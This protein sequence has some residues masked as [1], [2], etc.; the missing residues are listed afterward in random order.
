[1][2][3]WSWANAASCALGGEPRRLQ[4]V[5]LGFG[6]IVASE[7]EHRTCSCLW[8]EVGERQYKAT[9]RLSP[10][11]AAGVRRER[12]DPALALGLRCPRPGQQ[13]SQ[14]TARTGCAALKLH[15]P[16]S[17]P[18]VGARS[19]ARCW[20]CSQPRA[21]TVLSRAPGTHLSVR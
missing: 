2:K 16:H 4:D 21:N 3:G 7:T 17:P 1:M 11:L 8:Y 10:I 18:A 9:M 12:A 19:S 20:R 5:D 6:R 15:G 13:L 14:R